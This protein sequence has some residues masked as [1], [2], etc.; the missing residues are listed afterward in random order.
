M[1]LP[2]QL[3]QRGNYFY[4]RLPGEKSFHS[5]GLKSK[6][7]AIDLIYE[8]IRQGKTTE[9]KLGK[10][11]KIFF[12]WDKCEWIRRQHAKGRDFSKATADMRRGHLQN[13][14]LPKFGDTCLTDLNP[15]K[16]ENW[17]VSLPLAN[18]TKNHILYTLNIILKEAKREKLILVNPID[19]VEPMAS[20]YVERD[21]FSLSELKQLF[22]EERQELLKIWKSLKW[23]A[24]FH[25]MAATGIR[26]GEIRALPWGNVLQDMK[27]ILILQA[28]KADG[29]IG[30]PKKKEKRG[31]FLPD[32]TYNLL[33]EWHEETPFTEPD[34]LVFYGLG[35]DQPYGKR[36][37]MD[38]FRPALLRAGIDSTG[39]NLVVHSLRHTFVTLLREILPE[40]MLREFTGHRSVKMTDHYD[41]Q[42]IEARLN[43][44]EG[45]RRLIESIWN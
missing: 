35:P 28:V 43:K 16:I 7:Q 31:I 6:R 44:L 10:Y 24:L 23:A 34:H 27:A 20:D 45:S 39:Q 3:W 5:T 29:T 8:R 40:K 32:K 4:Y 25:V 2:F 9:T 18:Q 37:L 41:H 14:I 21:V 13:H 26:S 15:V 33:S 19:D 12:T 42:T 22:P 38:H 17:L 36:A 11:A 30:E 1:K